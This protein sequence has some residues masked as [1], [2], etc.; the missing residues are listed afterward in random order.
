MDG[1]SALIIRVMEELAPP[2]LFCQVRIEQEVS[3]QQPRRGL[4]LEPNHAAILILDLQ[5]PEL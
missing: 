2:V 1:I 4:S 5:P 3:S